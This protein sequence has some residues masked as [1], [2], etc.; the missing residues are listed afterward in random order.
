MVFTMTAST[1]HCRTATGILPPGDHAQM[2]GC[3][4]MI[5]QLMTL[6]KMIGQIWAQEEINVEIH[7]IIAQSSKVQITSK[8]YKWEP[9]PQDN[10]Q[11]SDTFASRTTTTGT[12]KAGKLSS[13]Q[14]V[15]LTFTCKQYLKAIK[16][17][18]GTKKA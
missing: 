1:A 2:Q 12:T 14:I 3:I 11:Q 6:C 15:K 7:T 18:T 17:R 5:L 10:N 9:T 13:R 8:R 16:K 4:Q